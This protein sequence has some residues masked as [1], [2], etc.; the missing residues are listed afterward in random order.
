MSMLAGLKVLEIAD[1]LSDFGGRMLA[2][3]GAEVTVVLPEAEQHAARALAWHHGKTRV[4]ADDAEAIR[5]LAK[6][7]DV[8]L[9]GHRAGDRFR[10][11]S[12]LGAQT[13]YIKIA[14]FSEAGPYAGR[15]A[16]DLTLFALSGLMHVTGEPSGPPLKFPGQQSYALTGIQ[17]ATAALMAVYARRKTGQ[18]KRASLSAFQSVTLSNYREAIMYEWT[19][20]IGRRQ[21]N[22]LV[23]GKSGVRQIW[24]CKDG[25]V[26]W[27]MIDNPSMMRAVVGV[28]VETGVAGEVA[29]IDWNNV[30]V[31]D[32]AQPT[33][34]RWQAV[35]AAFFAQHGR[36]QL[37][38][39]SLERG[40]GLSVIQSPDDVRA[41]DQLT[42]RGLFVEV[43]DEATGRTVHVP[44]P[45]FHSADMEA[46]ARRL[47][48]PVQASAIAE[49]AK[50]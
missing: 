38:Q 42:A 20:R 44:G 4:L 36:D 26:T 24:P 39:W 14:P 1:G 32:T 25:F 27:S 11:S 45:L 49:G 21:G 41:S 10:L 22:M 28:M 40:W 13:I 46:P 19:G 31:A 50:Q 18:A 47:A 29:D 35:F 34:E 48:A 15:P 16:T 3:L 17:A 37:G 6:A 2:E 23:R 33:I 9:D 12:S 30:L 8:V 7:A 5:A 43:V